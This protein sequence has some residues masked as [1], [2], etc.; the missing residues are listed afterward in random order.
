MGR[1]IT[2]GSFISVEKETFRNYLLDSGGRGGIC[3]VG[4][5]CVVNDV[6]AGRSAA[7]R[8]GGGGEMRILPIPDVIG[9]GPPGL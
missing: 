2:F 8:P 9:T 6:G 1:Q 3:A 4:E 7:G 5:E